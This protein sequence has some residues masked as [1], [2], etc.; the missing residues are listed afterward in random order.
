MVFSSWW[1]EF[2]TARAL[3]LADLMG[4]GRAGQR[5]ILTA[6]IVGTTAARAQHLPL[7]R[8]CFAGVRQQTADFYSSRG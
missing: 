3:Q 8:P 1:F 4:L 2:F 6:D 7:L 5:G